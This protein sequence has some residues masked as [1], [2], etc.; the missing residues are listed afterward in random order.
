M[1]AMYAVYHR[2]DGLKTIAKR[3]HGVF[4]LFAIELAKL[5]VALP[6]GEAFDLVKALEAK[7]INFRAF[8]PK[9]VSASFDETHYPEDVHAIIA[10]LKEAGDGKVSESFART[11]PF[12]QQHIFNSTPSET[13]MMRYMTMLQHKGQSLTTSMV[14][15][16]FM[17]HE[18]EFRG[19]PRIM[20]S[21]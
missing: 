19:V 3:V 18:I 1:A 20:Q 12:L 9:L 13:E 21:A 16:Q 11:K 15:P 14:F 2:T 10:A 17:Q 4:Q 7:H 5:G 6:N 8:D